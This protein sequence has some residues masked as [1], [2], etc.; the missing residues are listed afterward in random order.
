M[1]SARSRLTWVTRRAPSGG[2]PDVYSEAI[3]NLLE[4]DDLTL[5]L[6]LADTAL[7]NHPGSA[8]IAELRQR[9][10]LRLA[11]RH[12]TVAPF[13]FIVYSELAGLTVPELTD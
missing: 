4:R 1:R 5:A 8:A 3:G 12:L 9:T 6:R 7:V 11:Q 10:L 2:K 13:K